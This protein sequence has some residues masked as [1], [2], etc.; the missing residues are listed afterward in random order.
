MHAVNADDRLSGAH[1]DVKPENLSF[2]ETAALLN[3][4]REIE[5]PEVRAA[6]WFRH[7]DPRPE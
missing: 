5:A 2:E 1:R 7:A 3:A 6:E 4:W